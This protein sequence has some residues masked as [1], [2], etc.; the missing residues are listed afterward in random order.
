MW[1]LILGKTRIEATSRL[2]M[3]ETLGTKSVNNIIASD[4]LCTITN[5]V[6]FGVEAIDI[7]KKFERERGERRQNNIRTSKNPKSLKSRLAILWNELPNEVKSL[8]VQQSDIK[9]ATKNVIKQI[10]SF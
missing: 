10:P 6:I 9:R 3:K 1:R 5:A 8:K 2:E 7:E 4:L